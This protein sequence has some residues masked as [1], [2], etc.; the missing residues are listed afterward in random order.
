MDGKISVEERD[1]ESTLEFSM[2][3]AALSR[4]DFYVGDHKPGAEAAPADAEDSDDEDDDAKTLEG[5]LI[6]GLVNVQLKTTLKGMY[7][8]FKKVFTNDAQNDSS[9]ML[10]YGLHPLVP[11]VSFFKGGFAIAGNYNE[12]PTVAAACP[13]IDT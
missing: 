6:Q 11:T 13:N 7:P 3:S 1:N 9:R 8:S 4:F 10:C 2:T 5:G 12:V